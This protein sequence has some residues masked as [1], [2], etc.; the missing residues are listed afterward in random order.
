MRAISWIEFLITFFVF[1]IIFY[2]LFDNLRILIFNTRSQVSEVDYFQKFLIGSYYYI[3][4]EDM[5]KMSSLFINLS[6]YVSNYE[7]LE[8]LV[9]PIEYESCFNCLYAY[10]NFSDKSVNIVQNTSVQVFS[11]IDLKLVVNKSFYN[12]TNNSDARCLIY[13][14]LDD[15]LVIFCSIYFY[16]NSSI[17]IYPAKRYIYFNLIDSPFDF[18]EGKKYYSSI[19]NLPKVYTGKAFEFYTN[20]DNSIIKNIFII[21]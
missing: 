9:L 12:I 2:I 17:K 19:R 11:R 16:G 7:T 4:T 15:E 18:Y 20:R 8:F 6:K 3:Q 10:Y 13:L 5:G 21:N 1:I 14:D